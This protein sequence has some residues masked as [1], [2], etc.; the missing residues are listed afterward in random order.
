MEIIPHEHIK[1]QKAIK[2]APN[3]TSPGLSIY[4]RLLLPL[5]FITTAAA[6][7]VAATTV[8]PCV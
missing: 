7:T 5:S 6:I 3:Y 8:G 4:T 1:N 2:K